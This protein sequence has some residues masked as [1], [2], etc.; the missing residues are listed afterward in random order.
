MNCA[1]WLESKWQVKK[2]AKRF[3]LQLWYMKPTCGYWEKIIISLGKDVGIFSRQQPKRCVG[4][5][6]KMHAENERP[7]EGAMPSE[8]NFGPNSSGKLT[9][10]KGC[11]NWMTHF[12]NWPPEIRRRQN[13]SN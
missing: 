12:S 5:S 1:A 6:L 9:T 3:R 8:L 11:W 4:S 7:S 10:I 13:W 2:P